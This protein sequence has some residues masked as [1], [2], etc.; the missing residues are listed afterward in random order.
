[1][2]HVRIIIANE[3]SMMCVPNIKRIPTFMWWLSSPP[4]YIVLFSFEEMFFSFPRHA[5]LSSTIIQ[6]HKMIIKSVYYINCRLRH[7]TLS[8]EY[9]RI[10]WAVYN[11]LNN[12]L[13]IRSTQTINIEK[14]NVSS[15]LIYHFVNI[16]TI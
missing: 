14:I 5:I 7:I 1:M 8:C 16:C 15:Q 4:I 9:S 3:Y 6:E 10:I 13:F 11:F 2:H 12:N